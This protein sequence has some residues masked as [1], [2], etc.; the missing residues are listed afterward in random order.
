MHC[1]IPASS[2]KPIAEVDMF[3]TKKLKIGGS[4]TVSM[5]LVVA[6]LSAASLASPEPRAP[7]LRLVLYTP[8]STVSKGD[9]VDLVVEARNDGKQALKVSDRVELDHI[10][11]SAE[12]ERKA[13]AKTERMNPRVLAGDWHLKM[14][15]SVPEGSEEK[16]ILTYGIN[17]T[18][19]HMREVRAN[20]SIFIK[21][22]LPKDA[23][24]EGLCRFSVITSDGTVRSNELK[25]ECIA[26]GADATKS[27]KENN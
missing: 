16:N 15:C 23:F 18:I 22:S 17:G 12:G 2:S 1:A 19:S 6:G 3:V 20:D 9:A 8:T 27:K 21:V 24:D 7:A 26:N 5:V 10:V 13:V 11:R 25:I 14:L 4:V